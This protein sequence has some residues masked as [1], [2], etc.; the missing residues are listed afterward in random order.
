MTPITPKSVYDST[1]STSYRDRRFLQE[2]TKLDQEFSRCVLN[3]HQKHSDLTK[4]EVSQTKQSL[5]RLSHRLRM[6]IPSE[7]I[8]VSEDRLTSEDDEQDGFKTLSSLRLANSERVVELLKQ[9]EKA[10][11]RINDETYGICVNCG[12]EIDKNTLLR[13]ITENYCN[14]CRDDEGTKSTE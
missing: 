4:E 11:T 12:R 7:L 2:V 13:H 8:E 14:S 10:I 1:V 5:I 3:S 9:V 6:Q